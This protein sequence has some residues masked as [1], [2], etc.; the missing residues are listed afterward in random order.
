MSD[1]NLLFYLHVYKF[2]IH[3]VCYLKTEKLFNSIKR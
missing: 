3:L 1:D 2:I